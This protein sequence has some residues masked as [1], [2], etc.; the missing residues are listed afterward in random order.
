MKLS[1]LSALVLF[2]VA[3]IGSGCKKD[4]AED[5]SIVGKWTVKGSDTFEFYYGTSNYSSDAPNPNAYL[6]FKSDGTLY[7]VSTTSFSPGK[8]SVNGTTMTVTSNGGVVEIW[9]IKK[10]TST[11]L[12]LY[13]TD[14]DKDPNDYYELTIY[15][16]R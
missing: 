3:T 15:C 14:K 11:E 7:A 16:G 10:L 2:T 9:T 5:A 4:K 6:E 12:E 8:W 13:Q 1:I